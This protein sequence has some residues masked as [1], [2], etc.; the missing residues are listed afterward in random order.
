MPI[1]Y[2]AMLGKGSQQGVIGLWQVVD[3]QEVGGLER[4][5]A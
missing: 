1:Y 3:V 2:E 4:Q 5:V